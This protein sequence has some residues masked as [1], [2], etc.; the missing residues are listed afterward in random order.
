M[1]FRRAQRSLLTR[2]G[3]RYAEQRACRLDHQYDARM[4]YSAIRDYPEGSA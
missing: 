4:L 3:G 1:H 2:G